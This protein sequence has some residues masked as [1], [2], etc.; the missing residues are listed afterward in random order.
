MRAATVGMKEGETSTQAVW[1]DIFFPMSKKRAKE[2]GGTEDERSK[3]VGRLT[4]LVEAS[5]TMD[6][7]MLGEQY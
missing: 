5:G 6:K 7:I 3:Y 4:R 2:A 1:N